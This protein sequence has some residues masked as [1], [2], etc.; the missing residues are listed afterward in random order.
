MTVDSSTASW[1]PSSCL[2]KPIGNRPC[3]RLRMVVRYSL[4]MACICCYAVSVL[5]RSFSDDS[6]P[7]AISKNVSLV[8]LPVTVTDHDHQFVSGLD[9]TQ[10]R[11]YEEG[12]FQPLSLFQPEDMPVTIGLVVDH[13]GS[14][15]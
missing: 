7:Y 6:P 14:M 13:S 9:A 3:I 1:L 4:F 11:V 10:F 15:E 2:G 5:A 8:V 12:R